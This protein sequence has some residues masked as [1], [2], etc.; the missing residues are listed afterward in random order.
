MSTSTLY[1]FFSVWFA[2][3]IVHVR[4]QINILICIVLNLTRC[5]RILSIVDLEQNNK[6]PLNWANYHV[7]S[8]YPIIVYSNFCLTFTAILHKLQ[9]FF[10]DEIMY[11]YKINSIMLRPKPDRTYSWWYLS[12]YNI[13]DKL[14]IFILYFYCWHIKQAFIT[15][16]CN[17]ENYP[18]LYTERSNS[19]HQFTL[20]FS[21]IS[22]DFSF[23]NTCRI[24]A[25][26]NIYII[27]FMFRQHIM[28]FSFF[29]FI[30]SLTTIVYY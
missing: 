4:K 7:T 20:H 27:M 29:P 28:L 15:L 22:A 1:S 2:M 14:R 13:N 23:S 17:L 30:N 8:H 16:M 19:E 9:V 18:L 25:I 3:N 26:L 12:L 21:P 24:S 11:S 10:V 6:M 5:V